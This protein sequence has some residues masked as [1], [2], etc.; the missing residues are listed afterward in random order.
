MSSQAGVLSEAVVV[1][2]LAQHAWQIRLNVLL[3][4]LSILQKHCLWNVFK[5]SD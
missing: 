1:N 5:M 4:V 2:M 3:I